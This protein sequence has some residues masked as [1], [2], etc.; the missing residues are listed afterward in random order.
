VLQAANVASICLGTVI[1]YLAYRR[2]VFPSKTQ[3]VA[4][5]PVY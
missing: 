1:R 5:T 4:E 2:W 3:A